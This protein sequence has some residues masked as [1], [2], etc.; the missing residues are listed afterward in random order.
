MFLATKIPLNFSISITTRTTEVFEFPFLCSFTYS[1]AKIYN[2]MESQ[3]AKIVEAG[4]RHLNSN[5]AGYP[6][7][8]PAEFWFWFSPMLEAPQ[9]L[10]AHVLVLLRLTGKIFLG[11]NG[12]SFSSCLLHQPEAKRPNITSPWWKVQIA[13]KAIIRNYAFPCV[14]VS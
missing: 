1:P 13:S 6:R 3:N 2:I 12:I 7:L 5:R 4:E 14:C 9:L 8:C 11:L 10:W